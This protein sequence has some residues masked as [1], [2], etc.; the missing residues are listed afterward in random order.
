MAENVSLT[1]GFRRHARDVPSTRFYATA[2]AIMNLRRTAR[3]T[4]IPCMIVPVID[5][6]SGFQT[7]YQISPGTTS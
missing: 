2:L 4:N 5:E 7:D 1:F 3:L 6:R